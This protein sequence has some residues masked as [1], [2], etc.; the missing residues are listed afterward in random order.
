MVAARDAAAAR[1]ADV[2]RLSAE[3]AAVRAELGDA[4]ERVA[5]LAAAVRGA[6]VARAC[7]GICQRLFSADV[8]T[9][10]CAPPRQLEHER[11]AAATASA[12]LTA[13]LAV[14]ARC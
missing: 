9:R 6:R 13:R 10:M 8:Y 11:A 14:R 12:E 5:E 4:K 7:V 1:D 3:L 2:R